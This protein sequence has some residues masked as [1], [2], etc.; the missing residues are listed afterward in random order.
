MFHDHCWLCYWCPT[1]HKVAPVPPPHNQGG[2]APPPGDTG[3][4][5]GGNKGPGRDYPGVSK[6]SMIIFML[7]FDFV[8]VTD[9]QH[10]NGK[11]NQDQIKEHHWQAHRA[12]VNVPWSLILSLISNGT[13]VP[14]LGPG[15][16]STIP[17]TPVSKCLMIIFDFVIDIQ[18][19]VDWVK[20]TQQT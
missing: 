5:P 11:M 19:R 15:Q 16:G 2:T 4:K 14:K 6:C 10:R 8:T 17:T 9:F 20:C 1:Q 12:W 3:K 7:I 13:K 18:H